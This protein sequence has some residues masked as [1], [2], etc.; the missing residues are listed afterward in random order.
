MRLLF[1]LPLMTLACADGSGGGPRPN[2]VPGDELYIACEFDADCPVELPLCRTTRFYL[3]NAEDDVLEVRQCT[4]ECQGSHADCPRGVLPF[5]GGTYYG[6]PSL[7]LSVN[8]DVFVY[9]TADPRVSYCFANN[10][11]ARFD[12][13][14][15]C[16]TVGDSL[17][18]VWD[19]ISQYEL[20]LTDP[21]VSE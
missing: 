17:T 12:G 2:S 15:G 1:I 5:I 14:D 20:C 19:G 7:C 9:D 18:S 4:V 8:D 21:V 3:T 10:T 13:D 16:A 6:V 11:S